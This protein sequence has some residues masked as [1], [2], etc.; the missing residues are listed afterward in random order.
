MDKYI[1]IFLDTEAT[2]KAV[3]QAGTAIFQYLYHGPNLTLGNI[4]YKMF[5]RKVAAEMVKPEALPP[6]EGAA[7]QHSFRAYL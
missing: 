6:T 5:S 4:R 3:T 2:K 7:V 1:D